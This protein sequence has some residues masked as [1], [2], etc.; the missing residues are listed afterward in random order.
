MEFIGPF[1]IE[2]LRPLRSLR[3]LTSPIVRIEGCLLLAIVHIGD[4]DAGH[5]FVRASRRETA[6][7]S[8]VRAGL[9]Y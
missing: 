1:G 2:G 7:G 4:G 8:L 5:L 9:I 6:G 3:I